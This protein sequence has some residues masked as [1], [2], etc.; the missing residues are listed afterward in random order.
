MY[1]VGCDQH[2]HYSQVMVKDKEG[3]I[4][5]QYKLYHSD[6]TE[7]QRYFSSLPKESSVAVE[8]TGYEM[9]LI[10]LLQELGL[11]V[12]LA[13]PL[14]TKAIAEKKI[15]TDKISA[16]VLA[17][18]L[19]ADLLCEAYIAP[20]QTREKR[21][22]MRYRQGLVHLKITAKNK[23][24][25]ILGQLGL[26]VPEAT[27]LFGKSGRIYLENLPMKPVYK[28]AVESYLQFID[29]LSVKIEELD[30]EIRSE[31]S[32]DAQLKLLMS[33]PGIGVVLGHLILAEIGDIKR[34][35]SSGKLASYAGIVPSLHESGTSR[36]RGGIT[37][38]G[39]KYL[40]WA[41]VEA[42]HVAVRHDPYLAYYCEKIRLKKGIQTAIIA[43]AHKLLIYAYQVLSKNESYKYNRMIP[44]R[45]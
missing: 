18:L 34:F 39:N 27:D 43:C 1:Y 36:R 40:R 37:K 6:R 32:D 31:A 8:A 17:D 15:M 10:D 5:D 7:V 41:F 9:W 21:F 42:A 26:V 30:R 19:R 4:I 2:K 20:P 11:D 16:D 44:G 33:I 29:T 38:Q 23:I 45:V 35:L 25:S 28:R 13:H 14:R 12:K 24:H 22:R 3:A